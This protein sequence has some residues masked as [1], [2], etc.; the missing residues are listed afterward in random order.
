MPRVARIGAIQIVKKEK[1]E[2]SRVTRVKRV[3]SVNHRHTVV[4]GLCKTIH[5]NNACIP[6]EK[7]LRQTIGQGHRCELEEIRQ[8]RSF[9]ICMLFVCKDR[10]FQTKTSYTRSRFIYPNYTYFLQIVNRDKF[11]YSLGSF[12]PSMALY[13]LKSLLSNLHA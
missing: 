1:P 10:V 6:S 7:P 2:P 11:Y 13:F 12:C 8:L 5:G 9:H 4:V 3:G